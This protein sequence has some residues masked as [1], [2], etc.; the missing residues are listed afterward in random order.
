[1]ILQTS[2]DIA[3]AY[4][5]YY[6]YASMYYTDR[7]IP[8]KT[9][10]V[11]RCTVT[12]NMQHKTRFYSLHYNATCHSLFA[13]DNYGDTVPVKLDYSHE[14][15]VKVNCLILY[16]TLLFFSTSN[17][18]P[19]PCIVISLACPIWIFEHGGH[20]TQSTN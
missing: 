9:Y 7:E 3:N 12:N 13:K 8:M 18:Q 14:A 19:H 11:C 17:P 6:A 16:L 10:W 4:Y 20:Q 15:Y 5:A 2:L 1:M